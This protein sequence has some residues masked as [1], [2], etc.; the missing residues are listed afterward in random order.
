VVRDRVAAVAAVAAA[1]AAA[2]A[3]ADAAAADAGGV[4]LSILM[5]F[6]CR[7]CRPSP[8]DPSTT[9]ASPRRRHEGRTWPRVVARSPAA[10]ARECRGWS[11]RCRSTCRR[12]VVVCRH[13]RPNPCS[14]GIS[15]RCPVARGLHELSEN[16]RF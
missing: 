7:S 5:R 13:C 14:R 8:R 1:A 9:S 15:S 10:R 3:A 6:D 16:R 4:G 12:C 2:A 11:A